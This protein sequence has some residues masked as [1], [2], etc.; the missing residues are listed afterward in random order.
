MEEFN[1]SR[2]VQPTNTKMID[3]I[4]FFLLPAKLG[5]KKVTDAELSMRNQQPTIVVGGK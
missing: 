3:F 5:N 2:S 4:L 1:C